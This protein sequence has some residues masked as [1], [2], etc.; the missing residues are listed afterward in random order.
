MDHDDTNSY[1]PET[2]TIDN[3][4][5]ESVYTYYV[6]NY[7]RSPEL[8]NSDARVEVTFNR[9]QRT[10]HVPNEDGLY[11]KVFEI[12]N[13]QIVACSSNCVQGSRNSNIVRE[14]SQYSDEVNLFRNL[15]KK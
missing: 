14:I 3:P 7:S 15:P 12:V 13:G 9:T 4:A 11:W 10:F 1:G 8:K 2:T 6:Y 5:V